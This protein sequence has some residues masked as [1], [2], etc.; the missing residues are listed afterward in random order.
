MPGHILRELISNDRVIGGY[1]AASAEAA[2]E[3][4]TTFVDGDIFLTDLTTAELVKVLENTYRDVNI[5][6]A[7]E[8]ALLCE[9]L[10]VDYREA[11]RLANRHPRVDLHQA[12]PGVGGHCIPVDPWFLVDCFPNEA[13]IVRLARSRNDGMPKHVAA[14]TRD[15]LAGVARPKVAALGLAFKGNVD[16]MR[17][18]PSLTVIR[19][20]QEAGVSV[21][22]HDPFV[23][24]GVRCLG[25]PC[26]NAWMARIACSCSQTT[27]RTASWTGTRW[28]SAC[29]RG[30]STTRA[31]CWTTTPG[32][33]RV[34][35]FGFWARARGRFGNGAT[36]RYPRRSWGR[37]LRKA[38]GRVGATAGL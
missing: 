6:L 38:R 29:A 31:T 7:N 24:A 25:C 2:R 5:A 33:R 32:A 14:R 12:G 36:S 9:S 34:S 30:R 23:K 19:R 18:S 16:D 1:D 21:A 3:L 22:A 11:A 4:Y 13:A 17:E 26:R 8:T 20:L 15:L 28:G 27:M 37:F 10:G 35:A